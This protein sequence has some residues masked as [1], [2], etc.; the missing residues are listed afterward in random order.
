[1]A[2]SDRE[3]SRTFVLCPMR[4][5]L[6]IGLEGGRLGEALWR[7][8]VVIA[9]ESLVWVA[10]CRGDL[11]EEPGLCVAVPWGLVGRAWSGRRCAVGIGGESLVR[12]ALCRCDWWGEHGLGGGVPL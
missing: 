6:R 7:C 8:A 4:C 5:A 1:M 12:V 3:R 11:W 10:L 2:A 9:G